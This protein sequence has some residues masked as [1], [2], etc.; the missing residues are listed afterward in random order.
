M[1]SHTVDSNGDGLREVEA[2]G[3]FEGGNLASAVQLQ[4]LRGSFARVGH[5]VD[6]LE[7][8]V[9]V[10]SSDQD[11]KS[12]TVFLIHVRKAIER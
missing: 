5:G 6:K 2:V 11:G 3:T 4:V 1:N 9:I 12:A 10:L 7:L 8:E